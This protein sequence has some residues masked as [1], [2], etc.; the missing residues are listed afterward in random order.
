M[1]NPC[2]IY[3]DA[4]ACPVKDEI[5]EISSLHSVDLFFI[6]SY[7]HFAT[8]PQTSQMPEDGACE[9]NSAA[10]DSG[11]GEIRWI[12]VDSEPEEVDLYI[13]NH[14]RP[15]DIVVTQDHALASLLS[16]RQVY[17]LTPRGKWFLEGEMDAYLFERYLSGKQRRAGGHVKGPRKMLNEDR[18]HFRAQLKKIL[19]IIEGKSD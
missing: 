14:A 1:T 2:R 7:A 3:V 18:E 9:R 8:K 15:Q 13:V 16:V 19:S 17:V 11:S 12:Y 5:A 4:D 10:A 6:A